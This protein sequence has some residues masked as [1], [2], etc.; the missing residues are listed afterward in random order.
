MKTATIQLRSLKVFCDVVRRRSFSLAAAEHQITQSAASQTVQNLEDYLTVQLID[1]SKRPFVL[2]NEGKLFFDGLNSI[3]RLFDTLVEE[4]KETSQE[5]QG[6]VKVAAIYSVGLNTLPAVEAEFRRRYPLTPVSIQLEHPHEVYRMVEQGEADIGLISYPESSKVIQVTPWRDEKMVLIASPTHPLAKSAAID[7]SML[8]QQELVAFA[9][10]LR[11]RH[12]IQ[13][14]LRA[15]G[16]SMR[17]AIELD[18]IDSIKH[19][20]MIGNGLAIIPEASALREL[21]TGAIKIVN[22]PDLQFTRSLGLLQRRHTSLLRAPRAFFD[23]LMEDPG[24]T[25]ADASQSPR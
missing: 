25:T 6:S 22:C 20:V 13:K 7:P 23:L 24:L 3:L 4:I 2:T 1:R 21:Q 17:V 14:Q 15:H 11:I 8:H 18:N 10:N 5:M 12:E 19:A 9:S 16:I